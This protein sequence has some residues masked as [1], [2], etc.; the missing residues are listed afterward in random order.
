MTKS[1]CMVSS[2]LVK[3][4]LSLLVTVVKTLLRRQMKLYPIQKGLISRI[5]STPF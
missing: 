2:G 3:G 1:L 5:G 4:S